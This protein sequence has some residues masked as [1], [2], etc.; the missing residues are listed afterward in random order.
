MAEAGK[1]LPQDHLRELGVRPEDYFNS[2][3]INIYDTPGKLKGHTGNM[4]A[5]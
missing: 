5:V 2:C 1:H 4:Y 3:S